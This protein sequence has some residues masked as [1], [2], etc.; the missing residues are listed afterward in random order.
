M[1]HNSYNLSIGDW[2]MLDGTMPLVKIFGMTELKMFST[3]GNHESPI[4]TWEVMTNRLK[5]YTENEQPIT[6]KSAP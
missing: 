6:P 1:N 4:D 3:I 2:V 5:P